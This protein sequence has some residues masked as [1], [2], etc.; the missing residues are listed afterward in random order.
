MS[1][2]HSFY[3]FAETK[4]RALQALGVEEKNYSQ[5]VILNLLEKLPDSIWLTIMQ[6]KEYLEWMLGDT[7]CGKLTVT[8]DTHIYIACSLSL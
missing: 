3:N 5:V 2:L 4:Y 8:V 1:R 7:S 6:E